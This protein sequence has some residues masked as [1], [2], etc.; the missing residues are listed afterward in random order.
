MAWRRLA[1]AAILAV[2]SG[3]APAPPRPPEIA[4]SA[5]AAP[6]ASGEEP[7]DA[8]SRRLFMLELA[9]AV[10]DRCHMMPE[11]VRR[12]FDARVRRL[13]GELA[14]AAG[15]AATAPLSDEA[16]RRAQSNPPRCD[17]ATGRFLEES[18]ATARRL[19]S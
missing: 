1:T 12:D 17:G 10:D 13:A 7:S 4:P 3:C 9:Q 14:S 2:S 16:R 5:G 6:T 18:V 15:P 8:A 11:E 19:T